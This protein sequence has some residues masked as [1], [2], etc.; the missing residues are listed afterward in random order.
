MES[1]AEK[2]RCHFNLVYIRFDGVY[3]PR[4]KRMSCGSKNSELRGGVSLLGRG[5]LSRVY[6]CGNLAFNQRVALKQLLTVTRCRSP[7]GCF[8]KDFLRSFK[9]RSDDFDWM[10]GYSKA[11]VLIL[12]AKAQVIVNTRY[13]IA[14]RLIE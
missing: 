5:G 12:T 4:V 11:P 6:L 14:R 7:M 1:V 13:D 10:K 8:A 9:M 3:L 2:S